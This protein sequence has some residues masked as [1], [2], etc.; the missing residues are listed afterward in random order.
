MATVYV[1]IAQAGARGAYG[2]AQPLAGKPFRTET[3]TSSGTSAAGALIAKKGD[4]ATIF[5]AT[6][7]IANAGATASASAG[8]Y[9]P[10]GI[11]TDIELDSGD[12][13]RVIDA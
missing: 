11:P 6:A 8:K 13:V 1:T 3:I 9:C 5:C 4:Y 10:A 12:T 7:V 2:E